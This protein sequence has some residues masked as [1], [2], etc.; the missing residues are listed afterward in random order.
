[1]K[2]NCVIGGRLGSFCYLNMDAT[3]LQA[4]VLA[5]KEK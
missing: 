4:A 3:I 2:D 1:M 5:E